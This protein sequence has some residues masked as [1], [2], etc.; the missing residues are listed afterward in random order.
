MIYA[1]KCRHNYNMENTAAN[2]C[3]TKLTNNNTIM[4]EMLVD[5]R[6]LSRAQIDSIP[7]LGFC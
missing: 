7:F 6:V 5:A 2:M 3:T 1:L 4:K